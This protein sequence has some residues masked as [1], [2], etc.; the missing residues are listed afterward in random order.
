M[1]TAICKFVWG[2]GGGVLGVVRKPRGVNYFFVYLILHFY[3][4][5]LKKLLRGYIKPPP[6][7]PP[8]PPHSRMK[9]FIT[10]KRPF[11]SWDQQGRVR[12]WPGREFR[13]LAANR[14]FYSECQ[15]KLLLWQKTL[16]DLNVRI[17]F[18]KLLFSNFTKTGVWHWR[19]FKENLTCIWKFGFPKIQF[20]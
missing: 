9:H 15:K 14:N 13:T 11:R 1:W 16:S 18:S 7:A 12:K 5:I 4:Q 2:A 3:D 10:W 8:P 19:S 17:I 20:M 6:P